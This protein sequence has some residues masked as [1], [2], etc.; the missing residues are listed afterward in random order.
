M[1]YSRCDINQISDLVKNELSQM[2]CLP[3]TMAFSSISISFKMLEVCA[4]GNQLYVPNL[5]M[6]LYLTV[7]FEVDS[8]DSGSQ[9]MYFPYVRAST[10]SLEYS[11][12]SSYTYNPFSTPVGHSRKSLI[13]FW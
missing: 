2:K 9:V 1:I 3:E 12:S 5:N 10:T 8:L 7:S 4:V 13:L 11:K 6:T